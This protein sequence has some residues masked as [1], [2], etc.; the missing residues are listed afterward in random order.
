MTALVARSSIVS[1]RV[2]PARYKVDPDKL[3]ADVRFGSKA[4]IEV[5][6]GNVRFTP[7]REGSLPMS[8]RVRII[9]RKWA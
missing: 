6:G 9:A 5:N 2:L 3:L 7:V 8:S 4:D 1:A